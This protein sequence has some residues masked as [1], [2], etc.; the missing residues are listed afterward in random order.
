MVRSVSDL[1]SLDYQSLQAG[2]A[3]QPINPHKKINQKGQ[4]RHLRVMLKNKKF[5]TTVKNIIK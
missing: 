5:D 1:F 3:A 2:M 4:Q